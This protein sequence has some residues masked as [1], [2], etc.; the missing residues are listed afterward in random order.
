MNA[1]LL[2]STVDTPVGP[3]HLYVEPADHQREAAVVAILFDREPG[4][5]DIRA[6]FDRTAADSTE[7]P[8][9]H[10]CTEQLTEYFAGQRNSFSL[11]LRPTGTAFQ[12]EAWKALLDIPFGTT[13][14]YGEQ[15]R[16]LGKPEAVRAIGAANGR[17]PIG[18]VVPCHR[19]IGA[20]GNLTGYGGGIETKRRL[21]EHEGAL[22]GP[23][24][25]AQG[26][27][28]E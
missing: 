26:S 1:P 15:A 27:L 28:F 18:I 4:R 17:N 19:V 16:T 3:L 11:P 9:L 2:R 20:N 23:V 14:S 7:D 22:R 10:L 12:M 13:A 8:L 5:T 25:A 6:H 24:E 21:L